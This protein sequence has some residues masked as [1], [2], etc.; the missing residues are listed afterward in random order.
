MESCLCFNVFFSIGSG[1]RCQLLIH[2]LC[3]LYPRLAVIVVDID[4][5]G[6]YI[7]YKSL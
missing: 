4:L 5:A 1:S 7:S 3:T 2:H 6:D